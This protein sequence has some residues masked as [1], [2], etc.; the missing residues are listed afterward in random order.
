MLS[1]NEG[2]QDAWESAYINFEVTMLR[3]DACS[4]HYTFA[5]TI[6][7]TGV[8]TGLYSQR[9]MLSVGE[10]VQDA[11]ESAHVHIKVTTIRFDARTHI[12][13]YCVHECILA[14]IHK[15]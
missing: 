15:R 4:L 12:C 14:T 8:Y 6:I 5:C 9:E 1:V 7:C 11:W 10:G 2:V 3:C 13:L